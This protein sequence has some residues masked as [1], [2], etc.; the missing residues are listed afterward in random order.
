MSMEANGAVTGDVTLLA[1]AQWVRL[2]PWLHVPAGVNVRNYLVAEALCIALAEAHCGTCSHIRVALSDRTVV[3]EDNGIGLP[4]EPYNAGI[5]FAQRLFTDISAC[6]DHKAHRELAH[7]LCKSG[8][9]VVCALADSLTVHTCTDGM[10]YRQTF[11]DGVPQGEFERVG[12][13]ARTGTSISIT[14]GDAVSSSQPFEP[15]ALEES[16]RSRPLDLTRTTLEIVR[17]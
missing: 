12:P 15:Q 4:M 2:R 14:F 9:V 10:E 3:I 16:I 5:P 13:T 1:H 11:H 7:N 17:V 8:M 6:R